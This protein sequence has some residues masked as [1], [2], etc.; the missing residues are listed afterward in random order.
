[1]T[2][3]DQMNSQNQMQMNEDNRNG[4]NTM[5]VNTPVRPMTKDGYDVWVVG[6]VLLWQA[7]EE[8][9]TYI[10]SGSD[11][12]SVTNRDLHTVDFNWDW[13]FRSRPGYNIPRDGWDVDLY[14]THI[15]NNAHA[16]QHNH[17]FP[18]VGLFN[19]W[20][21]AANAAPGT[22]KEASALWHVHL[23]QVDLDLGR[24]FYV[25]KS[26]LVLSLCWDEK[27]MDFPGILH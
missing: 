15:R 9:L 1:M 22:I 13:G 4:S 23:D 25:G 10:Y 26:L 16:H 7:V 27:L 20:T 8:N 5:M 11:S 6:D 21:V 17:N 12:G 3:Q 24:Q 19:V 14:W 2:P 18:A